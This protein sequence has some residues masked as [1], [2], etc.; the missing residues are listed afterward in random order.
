M[1]RYRTLI[2]VSAILGG[3]TSSAVRPQ[4]RPSDREILS[5]VKDKGGDLIVSISYSGG[6]GGDTTYRLLACPTG[7]D[8]CDMLGGV[9]THGGGAPTLVLQSG[10]V[11]FL[12]CAGDSLWDFS[13][14]TNYLGQSS[15]RRVQLQYRARG[16]AA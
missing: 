9:D 16:C 10:S 8:Q 6:G 7:A 14:V 15:Q 4:D 3:C 2:L 12:I 11:A 5:R 1:Q 13:N